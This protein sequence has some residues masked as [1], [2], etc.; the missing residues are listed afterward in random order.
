MS[1]AELVHVPV[2]GTSRQI[3][4]AV[5]DGKPL[6]SLRHACEA[7]GVAF[8]AQL[9][10]LKA[11]SWAGVSIIDTP[12]PGGSQ[13]T[14]MVDRRTFTM[15]LATIDANRV[16]AEARPIIEAFQA[17][18]ADA[19]DAYFNQRSVAA[20]PVNQLDVLRAAIDQIEAAQREAAEAKA[21]AQR[22]D[23][24]LAAIEGRHDW[25]A[26]LGYARQA[27]LPTHTRYLA[28]LGKCAAQ[29]ARSHGVEPNPVQH[30]LYGRV[31]SFPVWVWD[32]AAEGFES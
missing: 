19:L 27:G 28:R 16:S 29:V 4:A 1:A 21:I 20:P 30:Q 5:V 31:N 10:K 14:A 18:A 2:P 26:A 32:L 6:V 15:W 22:T 24:R 25:L 17:E 13:Q 7:I 12:S 11:K 3:T 8:S 9:Q 23:D